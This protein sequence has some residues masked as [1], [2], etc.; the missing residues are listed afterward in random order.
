[1][2]AANPKAIVMLSDGMWTAGTNPLNSLPSIPVYTIALGNNGQV[3]T[4]QQIASGTGG[5]FHLSP[6]PFDLADIYNEIIGQTQVA[7]VVANQKRNVNQNSFWILPGT[8]AQGA[9]EATFSVSWTNW[10]ITYTSG[11]PVGN[12]VNVTLQ[13]PS[14]STVAATPT[15]IGNGFVVFKIQ[16]PQSGTWQAAIWSSAGGTLGTAGGIFDPQLNV[17]MQVE[18]PMNASVGQPVSLKARVLDV[19]GSVVPEV[20]VTASVESPSMD[21]EQAV[22]NNRDRLDALSPP[23]AAK[24]DSDNVRMLALQM[25][26]GP[27]ELLLPYDQTPLFS[28]TAK[29]GS[30]QLTFTPKYK[31]GHIV[32]LDATGYAPKGKRDFSLSRR[33]SVWA[34]H[35]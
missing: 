12:Q 4:L 14:G 30:H 18:A 26:L 13:N 33:I 31:G 17:Q 1:V 16:N 21:P 10:A 22:A 11:T 35:G 27:G 20:R 28:E 23:P 2:N 34:D 8:V 19:D 32:R 29:D 9:T 6:T 15:A 25:Q 3:Q 24:E 7:T 5:T